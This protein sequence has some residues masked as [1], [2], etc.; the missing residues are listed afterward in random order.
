MFTPQK[1]R[2]WGIIIIPA[3]GWP[4]WADLGRWLHSETVY[5]SMA[6]QTSAYILTVNQTHRVNHYT[7]NGHDMMQQMIWKLYHKNN[8][9]I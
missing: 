4:G 1:L 5:P 9:N 6:K 7:L 2:I 3:E 8:M